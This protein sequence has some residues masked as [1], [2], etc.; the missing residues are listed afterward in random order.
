MSPHDPET[1]A[2]LARAAGGDPAAAP[3]LLARHRDR[4]RRM[5]AVRLDPRL[6]ARLDPS[7]VVQEALLEAAGKLPE[8]LRERPLPFYPWLRRL[9]WERLLKLHQRHRAAKRDAA[10]DVRLAPALPDG[11]ALELAQRLVA[12]GTSPS[13]RAAREETRDRVRAALVALPAAD[14]EVLVLR[15]LEG[16]TTAEVAA[17]LGLGEGAVKMRHRRALDRLS[18]VLGDDSEGGPS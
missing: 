8:Y 15:Y 1:E 2:L 3:Q 14:R 11:S 16:M 10:R 17:V 5:V 6:A 9:A 12:S 13:G 4:L 7:D 18:R